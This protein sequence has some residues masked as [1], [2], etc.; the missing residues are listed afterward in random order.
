MGS[1]S[2]LAPAFTAIA[3]MDSSLETFALIS[4][5][6]LSS[7]RREPDSKVLLK[8]RLNLVETHPATDDQEITEIDDGARPSFWI[9]IFGRAVIDGQSRSS[10]HARL[11]IL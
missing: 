2:S 11:D 6:L 9:G 8:D 7:V 4:P 5:R 1:R 10:T 3:C